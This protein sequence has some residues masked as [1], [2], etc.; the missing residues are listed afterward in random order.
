MGTHR[1]Y[2]QEVRDALYGFV[3]LNRAE[4]DIINSPAF[5]R[6]R[7][8]KQ[9]A[10]GH[11]VYPGAVHTRLEHSIGC[12]HQADRIL[13]QLRENSRDVLESEFLITDENFQRSRQLLRLAALLHDLGHA[14]FSH[15][16]EDLLPQSADGKKLTH[17]DMTARLI[18]ET[19]IGEKIETWFSAD[20]IDREDVIAVAT[21]FSKARNKKPSAHVSI[22]NE[23]LTG[24]LGADRLDYLLRDAYHAG[25]RSGVFDHDRLIREVRLIEAPVEAGPDPNVKT[26]K[27]DAGTPEDSVILPSFTV[28]FGEGGWGVAEQMIAARYLMY[29][30]L[31]FHK[32]KRIYEIHLSQFMPTALKAFGGRLPDDVRS[33]VAL[34]DSVIWREIIVAATDE[35][36][37]QHELASRFVRRGHM[38]LAKELI[39]ADNF[40][41]VDKRRVPDKAR[42]SQFDK[43]V[44]NKYGNSVIVD[45]SDHSATKMFDAHNLLV[46]L[47]VGPDILMT[48]L[49]SWAECLRASGAVACMR[50]NPPATRSTDSVTGGCKDTGYKRA[51]ETPNE[52]E[53]TR[54]DRIRHEGP[55][56]R[57]KLDRPNA[58]AQA[59]LHHPGARL[60][61]HPV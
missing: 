22:L 18:R 50:T 12:V 55:R 1:E 60:G 7:D 58:L 33:Y 26:T 43:D 8:I 10:M 38:R 39:L 45:S 14:P 44:R 29:T 48:S 36:H 13:H 35:S 61:R 9:L 21:A 42:F 46:S 28:G 23:M 54:L 19:D 5:Q 34:S 11:M 20:G 30:G 59:P 52:S 53:T 17:E 57:R 56:R 51:P 31:Y 6:L 15:S 37:A 32:T 4:W 25:Q 49:K 2:K 40:R 41:Q 24:D 47:V 3:Y 27:D 16:G